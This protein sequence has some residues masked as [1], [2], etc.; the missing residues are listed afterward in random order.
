MQDSQI[1]LEQILLAATCAPEMR[2]PCPRQDPGVDEAYAIQ[3]RISARSSLPVMVWKLGLTGQGAREAFGASEPTVGR[4]PASAIYSDRSEIN[5][6]GTEMFAEA[7][8][9]FE[10]GRDLPMQVELYTRADLGDALKGIYAGIEIVRTRFET[11]DLTLPL[12]IADNSMAHGLVLGRKLAAEWEDRFA[13]LPVSLSRN[14]DVLAEGSTAQVMGNPLDALV[15]LAN[16]LREHENYTLK[17]EQLIASGT[18][19]GVTEI[20]AGD[21]ISVIF[22]GAQAARVTLCAPN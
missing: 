15:C 2:A 8:L 4:L 7:E 1:D 11:S 6:V 13:N 9:V 18:C 5:F 12:L 10:L 21:T 19:T 3:R 16:W 22:D 14:A 20:F 17:R